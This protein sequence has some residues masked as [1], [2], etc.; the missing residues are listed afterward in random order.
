LG[1]EPE[2]GVREGLRRTIDW[3]RENLSLIDACIE[4]H[5]EH[6]PVPAARTARP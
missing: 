4:K 5:S 6:L 2:I 3:T 1:F